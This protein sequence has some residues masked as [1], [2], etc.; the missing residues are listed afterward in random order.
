MKTTPVISEDWQGVFAVPPLARRRDGRGALDEAQND[1]IV[2][3]ILEGG[4]TRFIYGG[5]AFLYHA[6]LAEYEHLLAWL[7]A[8]ADDLWAIPSAGPSFGRAMDQAPLLR[9]HRFPCVMMLPC[10][11]PR[12]VAGLE[13]GYRAVAEAA[14][15]GLM[16]YLKEEDNLGADKAAGLDMIA[17]LIDDGVAV[18]IKY[19]VV[20]RN[21]AEDAYLDALLA[22][23]SRRV[24]LSGIGERP[25][26]TH[27]REW[28]L[29]GFT[30]GSGCLAPRLSQMLFEACG[31]GDF[32]QAEALRAIFLPL[33]DLRDAWNPAKV[34]HA[35]TALAGVAETGAVP[36]FLSALSAEQQEQLAPV[37]RALIAANDDGTI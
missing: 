37:A 15:C 28:R 20:R 3:H 24:V 5:N 22:R 16:L 1:M 31:R 21:P 35:A 12:D 4:V 30:T 14:D 29:P 11:D 6:T 2:R 32:D 13:R 33:E 25:A 27:M 7:A 34:L 8:F 19:A 23:A 26:V 10:N 9:K 36:P 17:R 18:G